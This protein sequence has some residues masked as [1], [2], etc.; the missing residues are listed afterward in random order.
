MLGGSRE[1][2]PALEKFKC[3]LWTELP[4]EAM[5]LCLSQ[6]AQGLLL[7]GDPSGCSCLSPGLKAPEGDKGMAWMVPVPQADVVTLI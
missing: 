7:G 3:L 1:H 4:L 6:A 2:R 5:L